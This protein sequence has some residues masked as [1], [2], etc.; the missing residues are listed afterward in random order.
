[1]TRKSDPRNFLDLDMFVP[2]GEFMFGKTYFRPLEYAPTDRLWVFRFRLYLPDTNDELF[3]GVPFVFGNPL[4]ETREEIELY[5]ES[6][7]KLAICV[8]ILNYSEEA[9]SGT[10]D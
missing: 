9:V 1:M 7:G 8:Q 3:G 5:A 10:R 2:Y 6:L 4:F